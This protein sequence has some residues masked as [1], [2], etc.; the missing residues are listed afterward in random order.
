MWGKGEG[1]LLQFGSHYFFVIEQQLIYNMAK[2]TEPTKQ[3]SSENQCKFVNI[4]LCVILLKL[5]ESFSSLWC[6][7]QSFELSIPWSGTGMRQIW[8][9]LHTIKR[10]VLISLTMI[11][12]VF[13]INL[14]EYVFRWTSGFRFLKWDFSSRLAKFAKSQHLGNVLA[15]RLKNNGF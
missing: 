8:L 6:K 14:R 1:P 15:T 4:S 13:Y 9:F 11:A 10:A 7:H 3:D 5:W 12:L 2:Q